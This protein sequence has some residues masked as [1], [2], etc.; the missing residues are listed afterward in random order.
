[1][2]RNIHPVL[3]VKI[4]SCLI[5]RT[6]ILFYILLYI[7]VILELDTLCYTWKSHLVLYAELQS[8]YT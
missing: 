7:C 5:R 1:M 8:R 6:A 3:Y 2:N 4:P